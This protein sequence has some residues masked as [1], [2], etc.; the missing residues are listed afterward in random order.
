MKVEEKREG[1]NVY[2][3]YFLFALGL[4][5]F[6]VVLLISFS[7]KME[8]IKEKDKFV[9]WFRKTDQELQALFFR[10]KFG[11]N[12]KITRD[13]SGEYKLSFSEISSSRTTLVPSPLG[14][15]SLIKE[16]EKLFLVRYLDGKQVE[17]TILFERVKKFYPSLSGGILNF[18]LTMLPDIKEQKNNEPL[19]FERQISMVRP[20]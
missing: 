1:L 14:R 2:F 15:L 11:E 8:N 13:K 4:A 6:L 7:F 19:I 5:V 12:I 10:L 17:K 9:H 20:Q 3:E 16:G 18:G